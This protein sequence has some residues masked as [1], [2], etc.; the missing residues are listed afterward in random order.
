MIKTR[1]T[2]RQ[3][4]EVV[5][6]NIPDQLN[7]TLSGRISVE[8]LYTKWFYT[9][10]NNGYRLTEAGDQ[11]FRLAEIEFY[12]IPVGDI[13]FGHYEFLLE[14]NKKIRCPFYLGVE[15]SKVLNKELYN[16]HPIIRIYDSEIAMMINLYGS[17]K[18]YLDSIRIK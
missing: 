2:K 9:G 4:I 8:D 17:L 10:R 15:K 1:Y 5:L 16:L 3:L 6:D 11:A 13:R 7:Y 14:L 18:E 12:E